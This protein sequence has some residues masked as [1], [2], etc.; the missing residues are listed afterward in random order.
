[1]ITG[2]RF[3]LYPQPPYLA[4]DIQP[5]TITLP[6]FIG[7]GPSDNTMYVIDPAEAKQPYEFPYLPP[8]QNVSYAPAYPDTQGHFDY[9]PEDS[10]EFMAAHT[11]A[12]L[13]MVMDIW[14]RYFGRPIR[15][16]WQQDFERLEVVP[17][18]NWPNAQSGYGY[19]E[20]GYRHTRHGERR[21]LCLNFDILAHEMGHAILFSELGITSEQG[22]TEH[23]L[24]FHE[25][26]SDL[27]ALVSLL[28]FES[29]VTQTLAASEGNLYLDNELNRIGELSA[30]EQLRFASHSIRLTDVDHPHVNPHDRGMP[31]TG[32]MFDILVH[33]FHFEL[34]QRGLIPTKLEDYSY[35]IAENAQYDPELAQAFARYYH[36]HTTEFEQQLRAARDYLGRMLAL[37]WVHL[38]PEGMQFADAAVL[39]GL[40]EQALSGGKYQ[41]IV[42]ECLEWRELI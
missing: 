33:I 42:Q 1:M 22:R 18:L 10:R 27:I 34:S 40:A 31:F 8:Y 23:Y 7:P 21:P 39:I 38:D 20:I 26:C 37:V 12:G 3:K 17:Q 16:H 2:S 9:L 29:V 4:P 5:E 35:Q 41:H 25:T 6:G 11:Y 19:I 15:W 13:R 36:L 30:T 32:A 24:A 14:Q 28:H